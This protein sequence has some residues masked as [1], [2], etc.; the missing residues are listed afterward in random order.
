[1]IDKMRTFFEEI[2]TFNDF[3]EVRIM[4]NRTK[5][6]FSNYVSDYNELLKTLDIYK[7]DKFNIYYGIN[8]RKVRGRK[9]IDVELR[10]LFYF[11]VEH[12]Q[13]KPP[14]T[15]ENYKKKLITTIREITI[16]LRKVYDIKPCAIVKSGRGYHL[17][18]KFIP[19]NAADYKKQFV[20]WFKQIQNEI[21]IIQ[22][23]KD[24]KITDSVFNV[25]RIASCPYTKHTKYLEKPL[26]EILI[27]DTKKINDLIPLIKKFKVHHIIK[28]KQTNI[29]KKGNKYTKDTIFKSPEFL[30]IANY[31]N[32]PEGNI[33]NHLILALKLL[34]KE[35]NLTNFEDMT[36]ALNDLGYENKIMDW[37]E[38]DEDYEYS[39]RLLIN[40]CCKNYDWCVDNKYKLPYKYM[41]RKKCD[42]KKE[43]K[44]V[45][46]PDKELKTFKQ[47]EQYVKAFNKIHME[48]RDEDVVIYYDCLK[49]KI[50]NNI[51]KPKLWDFIIINK[52]LEQILLLK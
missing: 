43:S 31:D 6:M 46:F 4:D 40:W 14:L 19:F 24:I 16:Y 18:Y 23:C 7:S 35:N 47:V 9:D 8:T 11:D 1:M 12:G 52:L 2:V 27:I 49:N 45:K 26:R 20:A 33:N 32:L 3:I 28:S 41:N 42:I 29:K 50:K 39:N 5:K 48:E 21:E 37:T 34:M 44:N 22:S 30:L 36:L 25:S 51:I 13:V 38:L 17:Y 10:N 15:N